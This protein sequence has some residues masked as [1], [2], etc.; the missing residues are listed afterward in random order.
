MFLI[1]PLAS[2]LIEKAK[3]TL[4]ELKKWFDSNKLTLHLGKSTYTIFQSTKRSE[5]PYEE[6]FSLNGTKIYRTECTKYLG[7]YI[8]DKLSWKNHVNELNNNLIKYTGIFH[9]IR[10]LIPPKMATQLYHAFISSKLSYGIEVYGMTKKS[11]IKP[12]Q[13]MQ[14]RIL[15]ILHFKNQRYPTQTLYSD[16]NLL[17]INEMH[18]HQVAV[19]IYKHSKDMLPP[20][21]DKIFNPDIGRCP[22][23]LNRRNML[24][25]TTSSNRAHGTLLFNNYCCKLWNQ[26]PN[27]IKHSMSINTFKGQIKTFL[28]HN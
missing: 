27:N 28:M 1:W 8:D 9:R 4:T 21:F 3:L 14:N 23:S 15:K 25:T 7:L 13:V 10:N 26:I 12:L 22:R 16:L 2:T 5:N 18:M 19:L 20:I 6:Y 17:K 11:T 24:F